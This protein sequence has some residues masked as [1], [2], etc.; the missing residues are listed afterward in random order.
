M[1][2]NAYVEI[3]LV[4]AAEL[5]DLT[6]IRYD[7]ETAQEFARMALAQLSKQPPDYSWLAPLT[8]AILVQY[9]RPFTT[10]VRQRLDGDA[11]AE[12]T[13]EQRTKHENFCAVRN[14]HVAH[15]ANTF[16]ES[17]PIA[18]YWVERVD[19]EGI[20]SVECNHQRVVGLSAGDLQDVIG[21][22]DVLLR[23][24]NRRLQEEK[25][26]ALEI[27]RQMPIETVLRGTPRV[28]TPDV[29][30]PFKVRPVNRRGR[31]QARGGRSRS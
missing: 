9:A 11:L 23:Y 21:L 18:R 25:T 6:G 15:S 5:A 16:E 2:T 20:T 29:T 27:V 31:S 3:D 7:L 13:D 4:D 12:F 1:A 19:Q 10:G 14:K 28:F 17:Q 8:V 22:A 30:R 26:K 24:V